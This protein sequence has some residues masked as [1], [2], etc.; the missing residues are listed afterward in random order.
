MICSFCKRGADLVSKGLANNP[1]IPCNIIGC[2][3]QHT[4]PIKLEEQEPI[5]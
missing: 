1:H 5:K 4:V 3:C 2:T